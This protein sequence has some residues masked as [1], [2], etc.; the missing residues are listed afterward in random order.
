MDRSADPGDLA[1]RAQAVLLG[2]GDGAGFVGVAAGAK[3]GD[4]LLPRLRA[5]IRAQMPGDLSVE[6]RDPA[7]GIGRGVAAETAIGQAI[8]D[9]VVGLGPTR[10]VVDQHPDSRKVQTDPAA[11]RRDRI[12]TEVVCDLDRFGHQG[13]AAGIVELALLAFQ[14]SIDLRPDEEDF[15]GRR[16]AVAKIERAADPRSGQ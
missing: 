4:G 15:P 10:V 14:I 3:R 16:K 1:R 6:P 9:D 7:G 5:E 2:D 11:E 13:V 8:E 12:E